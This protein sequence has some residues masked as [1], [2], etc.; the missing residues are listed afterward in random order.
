MHDAKLREIVPVTTENRYGYQIEGEPLTRD[1][2]NIVTSPSEAS[3]KCTVSIPDSVRCTSANDCDNV[4]VREPASRKQQR[5]A[6]LDCFEM[7]SHPFFQRF[8]PWEMFEL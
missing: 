2:P 3:K 5:C 4:D 7:R 1:I 6:H 8:N